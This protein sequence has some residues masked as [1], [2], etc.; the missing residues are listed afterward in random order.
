MEIVIREI[1][2]ETYH[3]FWMKNDGAVF[4]DARWFDCTVKQGQIIRYFGL[5]LGEEMVNGFA[6]LEQKGRFFKT[7]STPTLTP[8]MGGIKQK[9]E[10][11]IIDFIESQSHQSRHYAFADEVKGYEV[12]NTYQIDLLQSQ[13]TLFKNLR[14]DKKRNIKKAAQS[15]LTFRIESNFDILKQN[16]ATTFKRQAHGF[17]S[18]EQLEKII[19]QYAHH[20]QIN[21][22]E[23]EDCLATLLF[24][25][26]K[27]SAYYLIGGFDN[28]KKNYVAGPFAMWQGIVHA[29]EL[30]CS[31]FDF[32]GSMIPSIAQYFESFGAQK[33][34]YSYIASETWYFR[35]IKKLLK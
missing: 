9:D 19:H 2:K 22:F 26:D 20:F 5:F 1:A 4:T 15:E 32:E 25:Y 12:V 34:T 17:T 23:K 16:V 31:I 13:E 6:F 21:V 35:L 29:K 7:I 33:K 3:S 10:T 11:T 28:A 30:G 27:K 18:Y 8:Y 24:V 14:Q